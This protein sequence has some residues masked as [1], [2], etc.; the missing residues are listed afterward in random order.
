MEMLRKMRRGVFKMSKDLLIDAVALSKKLCDFPI[1]CQLVYATDENF[2]GRPIDGYSR[3]A[4]NLCLLT[5]RV[6]HVLCDIQNDLLEKGLS[7]YVYD[8]YRPLRA[9][10]DFAKWIHAPATNEYELQRKN[11]H[12][13][14]IK[15]TDLPPL[16]YVAASVSRHNFAH[17]ID[18]TLIHKDSLL[19]LDMGACFDYFDKISHATATKEEVGEEGYQNR[20]TLSNVMKKYN[21]MPYEKE[22]WHFEYHEQEIDDPMDFVITKELCGLNV[23]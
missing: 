10:Q 15:K 18:L 5:K 6:G 9:V 16:G 23:E 21:F 1:Q 13:S 12:Y 3:D 7:L 22:F 8:A 2:V 20:E 17:T 11:M 19:P 14:H 4:Q